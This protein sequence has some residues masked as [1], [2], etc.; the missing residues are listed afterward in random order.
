MLP[1]LGRGCMATPARLTENTVRQQGLSGALVL[2]YKK[3]LIFASFKVNNP[4]ILYYY[5]NAFAV[6]FFFF[7][8]AY[9]YSVLPHIKTHYCS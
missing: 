9:E 3:A 5:Y 4:F 7:E 8:S 6:T 2:L 1:A